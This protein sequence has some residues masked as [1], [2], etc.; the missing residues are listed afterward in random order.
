[1]WGNNILFWNAGKCCVWVKIS[2]VNKILRHRSRFISLYLTV[3][4][5]SESESLKTLKLG[6]NKIFTEVV[7]K[8]LERLER[9]TRQ[10]YDLE[11]RG[12]QG[13]RK[14]NGQLLLRK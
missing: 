4:S 5:Y 1:M 10:C 12:E 3:G 13:N 14:R 11:T 8:K 6:E 9:K 2:K 7:T